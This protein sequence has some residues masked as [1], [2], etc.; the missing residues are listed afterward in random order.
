MERQD[1][2]RYIQISDQ[3]QLFIKELE[4]RRD[5]LMRDMVKADDCALRKIAGATNAL[6]EILDD[7]AEFKA[8]VDG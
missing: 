5:E 1:A 4:L 7:F 6:T 2:Y 3:G 8:P